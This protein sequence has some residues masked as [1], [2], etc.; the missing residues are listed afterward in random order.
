MALSA[1]GHIFDIAALSTTVTPTYTQQILPPAEIAKS[2]P[3]KIGLRSPWT[4]TPHPA[5]GNKIEGFTWD[6]KLW[7]DESS[8]NCYQKLGSL[9]GPSYTGVEDLFQSGIGAGRD[10]SVESLV[11]TSVSGFDDGHS[12]RIVPKVFHGHYFLGAEEELLYSDDSESLLVSH[13]GVVPGISG[14]FNIVEMPSFCKTS[15]PITA[16]QYKWYESDARYGLYEFYKKKC[17][18]TGVKDPITSERATTIDPLNGEIFWSLIDSSL[19]EFIISQSGMALGYNNYP[20]VIFNQ[21]CSSPVGITPSGIWLEQME[22]VGLAS[23]QLE[24]EYHLAYCPVDSGMQINIFTSLVQP[25]GFLE[26]AAL[27]SGVDGYGLV[28]GGSVPVGLVIGGVFSAPVTEWLPRVEGTPYSGYMATVD[29]DLGLLRFG[30]GLGATIPGDG[31]YIFAS[32]YRTLKLEYEAE[33]TGDHLELLEA[34]VDPSTRSQGNS[35]VFLSHTVSDPAGLSLVA[36]LPLVATDN[37]GPLNIGTGYATLVATVV[38]KNLLPLEGEVVT[39]HI[40]TSPAM[41]G[42]GSELEITAITNQD[43]LAYAYYNPPKTI[44]EIGE[45]ILF[46]QCTV[47]LAPLYPGVTS[48][49]TLESTRLYLGTSTTEDLTVYQIL[50]DDYVVGGLDHSVSHEDLEAQEQIYYEDYLTTHGLYGPTGLPITEYVAG[51]SWEEL[52]RE[53]KELLK[54]AIFKH[55]GA[56]GSKLLVASWDTSALNPH[57]FATGAWAPHQPIEITDLGGDRFGIV[58]DTSTTLM[59]LPTGSAT[60]PTGNLYSYFVVAPSAVKLQASVLNERT[61][62][63]ITSQEITVNLAVPDYMNGVWVIDEINQVHVDEISSALLSV[64]A[65]GQRVPFGWRLPTSNLSLAAALGG[66]TFL[67]VNPTYNADIWDVSSVAPLRQ[68]FNITSII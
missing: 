28:D 25:T 44:D 13:G 43:G 7:T 40:T 68:Y 46:D 53:L 11:T 9:T 62:Q 51:K 10:L 55:L 16:K 8:E 66:I 52:H 34:N 38:D 59:P 65:A 31:E 1:I 48:T 54:P 37:Y 56:T 50:T 19:K 30:D 2:G 47:D 23:S 64:A 21:Q 4:T 67:D 14:D 12:T 33:D 29:Y 39:F 5:T 3:T 32:Y 17:A 58:Y 20:Q 42:F 61:R 63:V 22:V 24:Q 45:E 6:K 60:V 15:W 26:V 41:G 35:F 49:L 18:F 27:A 57:T 36:E